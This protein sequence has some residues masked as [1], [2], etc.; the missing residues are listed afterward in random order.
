MGIIGTP[1][2]RTAAARFIEDAIKGLSIVVLSVKVIY[3]RCLTA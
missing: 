2:M 1:N 3:L